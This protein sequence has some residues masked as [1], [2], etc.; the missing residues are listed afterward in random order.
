MTKHLWGSK[1]LLCKSSC[2]ISLHTL[3]LTFVGLSMSWNF[4]QIYPV[5]KGDDWCQ[6]C[7]LFESL[8][9]WTITLETFSYEDNKIFL[10]Q[11]HYYIPNFNFLASLPPSIFGNLHFKIC[12]KKDKEQFA[13]LISTSFFQEDLPQRWS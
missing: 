10:C 3:L 2:F 12:K 8:K 5:I 6:P 1:F 13:D 11:W 9:I 7:S 4:W